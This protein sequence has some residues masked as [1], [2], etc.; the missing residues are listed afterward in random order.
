MKA[1]KGDYEA[2]KRKKELREKKMKKRA[3][4]KV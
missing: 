3:Q 4:Q 2:L 1:K